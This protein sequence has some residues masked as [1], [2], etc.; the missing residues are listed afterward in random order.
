MRDGDCKKAM[1]SFEDNRQRTAAVEGAGHGRRHGGCHGRCHG[2][3]GR[4]QRGNPRPVKVPFRHEEE[5]GIRPKFSTERKAV[6]MG[7][8][9]RPGFN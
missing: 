6:K 7:V 9:L 4:K 8:L 5:S 1:G 3:R 2:R